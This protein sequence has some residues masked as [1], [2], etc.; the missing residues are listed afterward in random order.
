M[1]ILKPAGE[2]AGSQLPVF[3][4]FTP[5]P[6]HGKYLELGAKTFRIDQAE[7]LVEP[8]KQEPAADS[9]YRRPPKKG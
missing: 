1:R 2:P 7:S 9:G 4:P 8:R 6:Q 5:A 3:L